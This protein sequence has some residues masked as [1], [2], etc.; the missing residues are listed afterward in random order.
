MGWLST[1]TF[2]GTVVN[3]T[4]ITGNFIQSSFPTQGLAVGK[5]SNN[6]K[7]LIIETSPKDDAYNYVRV[8]YS[9]TKKISN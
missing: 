5:I 4:T 6:G 2:N 1:L 8:K 9:L 3:D 7:N